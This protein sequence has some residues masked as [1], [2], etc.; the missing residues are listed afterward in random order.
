MMEIPSFDI[1][2]ILLSGQSASL[3]QFRSFVLES[4]RPCASPNAALQSY[5]R[6]ITYHLIT[7]LVGF[8]HKLNDF[9]AAGRMLGISCIYMWFKQVLSLY[10]CTELSLLPMTMTLLSWTDNF[11]LGIL[12]YIYC[13]AY[14]SW[15]NAERLAIKIF[16]IYISKQFKGTAWH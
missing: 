10:K 4:Q 2:S 7:L 3:D 16:T 9:S 14:S 1:L 12:I 6:K 5:R 15:T 8:F 11:Q 13:Q